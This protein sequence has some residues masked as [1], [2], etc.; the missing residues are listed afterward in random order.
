MVFHEEKRVQTR[1]EEVFNACSHGFGFLAALFILPYLYRAAAGT[2]EP[3]TRMGAL[4]FG[5]SILIL[6]GASFLYHW[7]PLHRLQAKKFF[8]VVDHVAIYFLIAGSYTPFTLMVFTGWTAWLV[9]GAVWAMALTGALMK[10][11]G[12]L[13]KKLHSVGF[14][15]LMGWF[16]VLLIL[17]LAEALSRLSFFYLIGGGVIYSLGVIFYV[18]HHRPF[19][20]FVWHLFVLS[21]TAFHVGAVL[22]MYRFA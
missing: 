16:V 18:F 4:V 12:F 8:N 17:P 20:H 13:R 10:L 9:L 11:K 5:V 14:Y 1:V 2:G 22:E 15:L 7:T 19:F 3:L 21:G 6:Y